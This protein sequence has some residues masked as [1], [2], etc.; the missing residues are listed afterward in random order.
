MHSACLAVIKW[1]GGARSK[2]AGAKAFIDEKR[3]AGM[4]RQ[5][6]RVAKSA[7]ELENSSCISAIEAMNAML[8]KI[9]SLLSHDGLPIYDSRVAGCAGG[10]IELYLPSKQRP[11]S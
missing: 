2:D 4:L 1:G 9:H 7:L 3:K 10:L 11:C 8:V 5:Y 6:L